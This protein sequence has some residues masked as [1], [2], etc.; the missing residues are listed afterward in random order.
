MAKKETEKSDRFE[1]LNKFLRQNKKVDFMTTSFFNPKKLEALNWKGLED[2][3][4]EVLRHVKAYQRLVRILGEDNPKLI[5]SLLKANIHSAIQIA[6]IPKQKF[7]SDYFKLFG[8]DKELMSK[9]YRRAVAIRSKVLL[10]HMN[11]MQNAQPQAKVV[12]SNHLKQF[13]PN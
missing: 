4:Q 7:M 12:Q 11:V 6:A 10:K 3:Q 8:K 9:V 5:K 13:H 1:K 2:D